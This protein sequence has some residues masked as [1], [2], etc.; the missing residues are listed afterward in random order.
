MSSN[1]PNSNLSMRDPSKNNFKSSYVVSSSIQN[2]ITNNQN[3]QNGFIYIPYPINNENYIIKNLGPN[4]N[5]Y[6]FTN[7]RT[8]NNNIKNESGIYYN[9][10]VKSLNK[11]QQQNFPNSRLKNIKKSSIEEEKLNNNNN[12]HKSLNEF[13]QETKLI[14]TINNQFELLYS[15]KLNDLNK[16]KSEE[17]EEKYL[18]K[19][20]HSNY[21]NENDLKFNHLNNEINN[22]KINEKEDS[23]N[24]STLRNITISSALTSN[25]TK[26]SNNQLI[27]GSTHKEQ[28]KNSFQK[29]KSPKSFIQII[30]NTIINN[31][32]NI[33]KNND[34]N[35]IKQND[36]NINNIINNENS[37]TNHQFKNLLNIDN[38]NE[39]TISKIPNITTPKFQIPVKKLE[40]V[41]NISEFIDLTKTT[42]PIENKSNNN[43]HTNQNFKNKVFIN[44]LSS[45]NEKVIK[46]PKTEYNNYN[47]KDYSITEKSGSD[48][49]YNDEID[50]FKF[51]PRWAEDKKYI[52]EQ[53]KKQNE[54]ENYYKEIFGKFIIE[55][56]NLNMIFESMNEKYNLRNS[57]ADW[58][59]DIS[60]KN[61][62]N[63]I[64]NY[65]H[66][67]ENSNF[68]PQT[69]RQLHFSGLKN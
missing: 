52:E 20:E 62:N 40:P 18:T 67:N 9:T 14:Q 11:N 26:I 38:N 6:N 45:G 48:T 2:N 19:L 61:N 42:S 4:Q 65:Q 16:K 46:I 28:L 55:K 37:N 32:Q 24:L 41:N 66:L 5:N 53:I 12:N 68:F 17:D 47:E 33:P 29:I 15:K 49:E 44:L 27:M 10:D 21:K 54:N 69:N 51:I 63:N 35:N 36:N 34:L 64:I 7:L 60:N 43:F 25:N 39:F 30:P 58:K 13:E 8:N 59:Y 1:L 57:T 56:L 3:N 31:N 50:S 23:N 22:N